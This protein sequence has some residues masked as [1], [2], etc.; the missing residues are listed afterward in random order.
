MGDN[1]ANIIIKKYNSSGILLYSNTSIYSNEQIYSIAIDT[2][3]K[4]V[5]GYHNLNNILRNFYITRL[6]LDLTIDSTFG[7]TYVQIP[8]YN[9]NIQK[10]TLQSDGKILAA[11]YL[12]NYDTEN[13]QYLIMRFVDRDYINFSILYNLS[14]Q[15]IIEKIIKNNIPIIATNSNSM[16]LQEGAFINK[17]IQ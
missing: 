12:E 14:S 15:K 13:Y 10:I 4:I 17:Y 2:N 1:G 16:S 6:N 11:G 8:D 7:S 5:I 9:Q 3:N